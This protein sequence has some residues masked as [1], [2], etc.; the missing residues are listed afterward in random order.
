[1][2]TAAM[3]AFIT[4]AAFAAVALSWEPV[5]GD[6]TE[7]QIRSDGA[8]LAVVSPEE[9]VFPECFELKEAFHVNPDECIG[10]RLCVS[11]C[12]VDAITMNDLGK[13]TIDP[14][15]CINCGI[16]AGNCPVSAIKPLNSEHCSLYGITAEGDEVLLQEGFEED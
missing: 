10:C 11:T 12:P 15:L 16:C 13:A 9:G 14:E 8:V 5:E 1:M 4:S 7:L 3:A 6:Y 2:K